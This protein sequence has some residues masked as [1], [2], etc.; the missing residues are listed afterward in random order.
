MMN[1][2]LPYFEGMA[3]S[4]YSKLSAPLPPKRLCFLYFPNGV[5]LPPKESAYHKNWSWFPVG[6]GTDYKLTKSLVPTNAGMILMFTSFISIY[7]QL[8]FDAR[9]IAILIFFL[10]LLFIKV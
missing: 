8:C 5:G 1:C 3:M 6:E 7:L 2:M 4:S 9:Y 10:K